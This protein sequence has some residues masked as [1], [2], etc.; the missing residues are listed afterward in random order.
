MKVKGFF[1]SALACG[2]KKEKRDLALIYSERPA[3]VAGTFTQNRIKAAPVKLTKRRIKPGWAQAIIINSGNA[4]ACTGKQGDKDASLMSK[5]VARALGIPERLVL[6]ASTG[7]IGKLLPTEKIKQAIPSLVKNLGQ[8]SFRDVAEAIMTTDTFPKLSF[9]KGKVNNIPFSILGIAKGAGMI[10]PKMATMLAFF[11]TDIA[12]SQEVLRQ[13]FKNIVSLTFN[14]ISIDGDT[15]TNDM[16]LIFAN[17]LAKNPPL[18]I[19][20]PIFSEALL[21]VATELSK[22]IVKGGEGASKLIEICIEGSPNTE[23]AERIARSVANSPLVK[24]AIYG[25]DPN[26]GRLLA[27]IGKSG[28]KIKY[29]NIDI[30]FDEICLVKN[31]CGLGEVSEKKAKAYLRRKEIKIVINLNQGKQRITWYTCDLTP[32][33]VWINAAYRT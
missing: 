27:A 16:A 3:I 9:T 2:V 19:E 5:W 23:V 18:N 15:S 13:T 26:W 4:N 14:R 17:G 29:Q 28:T 32:E 25:K 33:Y 20:T 21:K 1:G 31:G 24:T 22:M 10:M 6:V 12:I 7:I 30:Y 8:R 11:I